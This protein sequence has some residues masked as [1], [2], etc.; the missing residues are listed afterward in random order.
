M[1]EPPQWAR[2]PAT[3]KVSRLATRSGCGGILC[4]VPIHLYPPTHSF[5][6]GVLIPKQCRSHRPVWAPVALGATKAAQTRRK[7][8][9]EVDGLRFQSKVI[10]RQ[11][12]PTTAP[13]VVHD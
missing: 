4:T 11:N 12:P 3:L 1:L 6:L 10:Q 13:Y 7:P 9:A 5:L 8:M 2:T